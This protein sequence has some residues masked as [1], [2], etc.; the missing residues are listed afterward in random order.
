M[1]KDIKLAVIAG[2]DIS[3][4]KAALTQLDNAVKKTAS[5]A[6]KNLKATANS[7]KQVDQAAQSAAGGISGIATAAGI[8]GLVTL[9]AGAAKAALDLGNLG[10]TVLK[11]KAYFEVWAG[12]ADKRRGR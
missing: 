11:Q 10:Q 6:D 5:D 4:A 3:K 8:G 7:F 9:A 1:S 12:G 2:G